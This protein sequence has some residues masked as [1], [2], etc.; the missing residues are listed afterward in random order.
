MRR[1]RFGRWCGWLIG[2]SFRRLGAGQFG[3]L[4]HNPVRNSLPGLAARLRV[5]RQA[6]V[7]VRLIHLGI[8]RRVRFR[9][10][11]ISR[12]IVIVRIIVIPVRIIAGIRIITA[13]EAESQES[14]AVVKVM[15]VMAVVMKVMREGVMKV[16]RVSTV[17]GPQ[18]RLS[19][20]YGMARRTEA[21]GMIYACIMN[22]RAGGK[23]AANATNS[24]KVPCPGKV[25]NAPRM[26]HSATNVTPADMAATGM[27]WRKTAADMPPAEMT[28]GGT[29][30]NM[31]TPN[32]T[33]ATAV[34]SASVTAT[35]MSAA[36]MAATTR[37]SKKRTQE[38]TGGYEGENRC[39]IEPHSQAGQHLHRRFTADAHAEIYTAFDA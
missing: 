24:S 20:G 37:V 18:A 15:L 13:V 16:T 34:T 31:S 5:R 32:M 25:T 35:S 22:T 8:N 7:H 14:V 30:A 11:V 3:P 2:Q 9:C 1:P 27:N 6:G 21:T 12:I 19:M 10:R 38:R 26:A 36:A 39:E 23:S 17:N 28:C 4:D 33:T 29:T